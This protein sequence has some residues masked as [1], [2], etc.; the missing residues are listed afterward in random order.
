MPEVRE[1]GCIAIVCVLLFWFCYFGILA[2]V[3]CEC[4]FAFVSAQMGQVVF[5]PPFRPS[6]LSPSQTL[7]DAFVETLAFF[8]ARRPTVKGFPD[9]TLHAM[10]AAECKTSEVSAGWR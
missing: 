9:G 2:K 10:M 4:L 3:W 5:P 8:A 7:S 6:I 1:I